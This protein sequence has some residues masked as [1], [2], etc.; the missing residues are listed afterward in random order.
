M[1]FIT[2]VLLTA[3]VPIAVAGQN[4]ITVL[5]IFLLAG[6]A[7]K[8]DALRNVVAEPVARTH[9][10]LF[11]A[12]MLIGVISTALNPGNLVN[13]FHACG[14]L[15]GIWLLPGL[16]NA[17]RPGDSSLIGEVS[18]RMSR[19]VPI[20]IALWGLIALTQM[21]WSW[22]LGDGGIVSIHSPRAQGF[23][24]HPLTLAYVALVFL[25]FVT[26]GL[27]RAPR[28]WRAWVSFL[29]I[30]LLI[31][32]SKS[33][34]VQVVSLLVIVGNAWLL[35]RGRARAITMVILS[36]VVA[37]VLVTENPISKR[38]HESLEA[39]AATEGYTDDRMVFWHVHWEM[40]KDRPL[41]GHGENLDT[42]YRTPYYEALGFKD[43]PKKYEAHNLFL[44]IL[45]NGGLVGLAAFCTWIGWII[46]GLVRARGTAFGSAPIQSVLALLLA[47]MTQNAFQ[48]SEVRY[49]LMLPV[50]IAVLCY[51]RRPHA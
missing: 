37:I 1:L 14:G 20:A 42:A 40:F 15:L 35:L 44:Q 36:A 41:L 31:V 12:Y 34:T 17:T 21:L 7:W 51:P 4:I 3:A 18:V 10:L 49:A 16:I 38:F 24:S 28:D 45:V 48:D 19:W 46:F 26:S 11:G 25:P 30:L 32:A 47:G 50:V 13:P 39:N 43:F 22:K 33:R 27:F 29:G 2:L 8:Q 23:Y 6:A 9:F 5:S